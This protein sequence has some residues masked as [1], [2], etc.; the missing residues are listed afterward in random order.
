M[1]RGTSSPS[2][3]GVW[4]RR[5][6]AKLMWRSPPR[7]AWGA[8]PARDPSPRTRRDRARGHR[9]VA[10]Q[11]RLGIPLLEPGAGVGDDAARHE[12]EAIDFGDGLLAARAV[13]SG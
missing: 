10:A 11:Y 8:V 3:T 13:R 7:R 4:M 9:G 6:R 2:T 5:F 12:F 1:V